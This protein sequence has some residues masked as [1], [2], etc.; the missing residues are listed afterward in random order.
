MVETLPRSLRDQVLD[1]VAAVDAAA[2]AIFEEAQIEQTPQ[3]RDDLLVVATLKKTLGIVASCF[4]A[5]DN[6]LAITS[7]GGTLAVRVGG[8]IYS[9][10]SERYTELRALHRDLENVVR[11]LRLSESIQA[12]NYV[13]VLEGLADGPR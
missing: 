1:Y 2:D 10:E 4:W 5:I 13:D 9:K 12:E 7:V 6:S 11:E 3:L 8:A